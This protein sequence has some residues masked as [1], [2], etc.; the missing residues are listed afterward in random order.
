MMRQVT[1]NHDNGVGNDPGRLESSTLVARESPR[2]FLGPEPIEGR[3]PPSGFMTHAVAIRIV[4]ADILAA[5]HN[6]LAE[7]RVFEATVTHGPDTGLT[8]RGPLVLGY[9]GRIQVIGFLYQ[10][11]GPRLTVVGTVYGGGVF[12]RVVIPGPHGVGSVELAG[13]GQL[14]R[15]TKGLPDGLSLVGSGN[16]SGPSHNDS[17]HW[18]TI[19]PP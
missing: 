1:E 6:P 11:G 12:L 10:N 3:L 14:Q 4:S 15:V 7:Y 2:G 18:S 19:A 5:R 13:S 9:S 8:L 17:G 16:L